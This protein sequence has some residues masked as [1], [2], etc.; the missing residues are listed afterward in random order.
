M[1]ATEQHLKRIQDKLQLLLKQYAA[2]QKE[3]SSLKKD[4]ENSEQKITAQQKNMDE[5]KAVWANMP[6]EVK[7]NL[8]KVK[9]E[10]KKM[11]ENPQV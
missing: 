5:L 4:L 10:L 11:Y 3:N 9:N 1:A 7:H 6:I 8:E 2:V